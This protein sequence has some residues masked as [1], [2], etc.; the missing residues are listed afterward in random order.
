VPEPLEKKKNRPGYEG[1]AERRE[2][3]RARD[4]I[5][6][7]IRYGTIKKGPCRRQNTGQGECTGRI[8]AH[9]YR[10][11]DKANA[12]KV[13]WYCDHH[14]TQV[15]HEL[16]DRAH[17]KK[18]TSSPTPASFVELVRALDF[19]K[20]VHGRRYVHVDALKGTE[21]AD[22]IDD[23]L[24]KHGLD[25]RAGD[26][27]AN[28]IK[29]S[30]REPSLKVSLL[31]YRFFDELGYPEL[32]RSVQVDL[33][34]G[35]HQ[36]RSY[37]R[38]NPPI[39]HR[40]EELLRSDD[41][42]RETFEKLTAQAEAAGLFDGEL[43][44]IGTLRGWHK[45][46]DAKGLR[47]DGNRLLTTTKQEAVKRW[48]Q[49]RENV[50]GWNTAISRTSPS[51]P[52][53][54]LIEHGLLKGRVLDYGCGRGDLSKAEPPIP[55]LQEWDPHWSD[56]EPSGVFD[57]VVCNYVLNVL[58]PG[59]V[60]A[61]I[62]DVRSKL[63]PTGR[64]FFSVRRDIKTEG[65]NGRGGQQHTVE[66]DLPTL[67][68]LAGAFAIY[69]LRAERTTTKSQMRELMRL[70]LTFTSKQDVADKLEATTFQDIELLIDRP[71]GFVQTGVA[72]DG[73][74]WAR[75]FLFDNGFIRG[76]RG[77]DGEGLDVF[78]G[79]Q[80][81]APIAYWITQRDSSGAFDEFKVML[82]FTNQADAIDAYL[83]HVPA[84][85]FAGVQEVT[86]EAMKALLG[87]EPAVMIQQGATMKALDD[88]QAAV[89]K[90]DTSDELRESVARE[91]LL[92]LY[93]AE[94]EAVTKCIAEIASQAGAPLPLEEYR[95]QVLDLERAHVCKVAGE[96]EAE[97]RTVLGVVL[98]PDVTDSQGDTYDVR[99]IKETAHLWLTDYRNIGL[100][101]K[102]LVN[103]HVKV[104][105][106]YI[107]PIDMVIEG[108]SVK[109]GTWL[110]KV[111]IEDDELWAQVKSGELTGFSIAGFATRK[112]VAA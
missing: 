66:L 42:R 99:T 49:K 87:L 110:I 102:A 34:T 53:R 6:G 64:A 16:G 90:G 31:T 18:A 36:V 60:N 75:E 9:H 15:H 77:G 19:G 38:E 55:N 43:N 105:E 44:T 80:A 91:L 58:E 12:L 27:D 61:I 26:G 52:S 84:E 50:V 106:S 21:L 69:E 17:Y 92:E 5:N 51:K 111:R 112:P 45:R 32:A 35:E 96:A 108:T 3:K 13:H 47:V 79:N 93:R 1:E 37:G 65:D 4:A 71:K 68:E 72:E 104:V 29:L 100:Q 14:H 22:V 76:T 7:A 86:V 8:I 10:G 48:L 107:A 57:T 56:N 70:A 89:T 30:E 24:S 94:P 63:S 78:V 95:P 98:E 54:W 81:D 2:R 20:R 101:H 88:L 41:P 85:F 74:E 40:K 73:T 103:R 59:D 82:G 11:Y 62:A 109:A 33:G 25:L 39:L 28:V 67:V 97:E 83:A 23:A 46:L